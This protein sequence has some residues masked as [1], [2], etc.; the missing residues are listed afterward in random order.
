MDKDD[1]GRLRTAP[2]ALAQAAWLT[3]GKSVSSVFTASSGVGPT[4]IDTGA[5]FNSTAVTST[6]GH[7]NLGTTALGTS[8]WAAA[9]LAMRKQV[10]VNSGER[11]GALTSP[12]YLLVPPDLE[13]TA[14]T[15]LG[16]EGV[17][18]TANNNV[19]VFAEGNTHDARLAA[20]RRRVIV[21]DLWTDTNNWAAVCDPRMYP[22]IGLGFRY[23][24][25][26]EIFSVASPNSGLMFSN[27]VMP[28]KVRWF[29]ACGPMDF[30]GM[31]KANVS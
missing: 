20:A 5:L 28:I 29:Y 24:E 16:S 30:R 17:P 6:G 31:Y 3:L 15:T 1:V 18:D 12:R 13:V 4:L 23:G 10:E 21:V 9:R 22:T 27:D 14:L 2:R 25:T 11:L 7:A 19:N 8:S 26:P